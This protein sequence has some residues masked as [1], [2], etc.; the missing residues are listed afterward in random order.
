MR[1]QVIEESKS[2]AFMTAKVDNP[3]AKRIQMAEQM[4]KSKRQDIISKR[5]QNLALNQIL[6]EGAGYSE[7]EYFFPS[8]EDEYGYEEFSHQPAQ[9][10]DQYLNNQY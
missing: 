8:Q 1:V 6:Q 3:E 4:R 2:E 9:T 10:V 5:R 7:Q